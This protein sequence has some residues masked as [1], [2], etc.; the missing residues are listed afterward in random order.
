MNCDI[1]KIIFQRD[2]WDGD[3][4]WNIFSFDLQTGRIGLWSCDL[5]LLIL[6]FYYFNPFNMSY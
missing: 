1:E 3:K 5:L 6:L 2:A 4:K